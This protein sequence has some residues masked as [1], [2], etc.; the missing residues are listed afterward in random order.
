VASADRHVSFDAAACQFTRPRQLSLP[1][2][3]LD[4]AGLRGTDVPLDCTVEAPLLPC[5]C[6]GTEVPLDWTRSKPLED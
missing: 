2:D 4:D 5:D 1:L 6:R 3:P